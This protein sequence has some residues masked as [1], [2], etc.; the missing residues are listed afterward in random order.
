MDD[1]HW[2]LPGARAPL[3]NMGSAPRHESP[4]LS[5][6]FPGSAPARWHGSRAPEWVIASPEC[7]PLKRYVWV[8]PTQCA[9]RQ[10]ST[11]PNAGPSNLPSCVQRNDSLLANG[12]ANTSVLMVGDSTSAQLLWHACEAFRARPQTLVV[13]DPSHGPLKKYT[14]RLRSLDNHVC[15]LPADAGTER[16]EQLVLGSFS[17]YGVT[18]PPYW[19]FAYPLPPWLSNTTFGMVREDM[20][21]FRL[22]TVPRESDPTV[23]IAS[24]GFWD[25]VAWWMHEGNFSKRWSLPV[26]EEAPVARAG[27]AGGA[28][29]VQSHTARYVIGVHRIVR[30]L[31]HTFPHS[32]VVWRMMHPGLKHSITPRIVARL[33]AA[34]RA[35]APSWRLPLL[36][37]EPMIVSLSKSEQPGFGG[38][39]YGTQDGRHLHPWL[40]I[41]LL[42]VILNVVRHVSRGKRKRSHGAAAAAGPRRM[43]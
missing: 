10:P 43:R 2:R 40:N 29:G 21:R 31:R 18:G 37:V 13:I 30:E 3:L 1:L 28:V 7:P 4:L 19:A 34:V 6:C 33:N 26:D 23:V 15:D 27:G 24:S 11:V 32:T 8:D 39:V 35:A 41:A 12:L 25:I 22:H 38:P 14:H 17:H 5:K 16:R 9:K 20:P 42:N 36:D